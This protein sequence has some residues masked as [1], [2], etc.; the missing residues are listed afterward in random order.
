MTVRGQ[1]IA[2]IGSGVSGLA[3]AW[4]LQY[5]GA[6]VTL[7]EREERCGGHTLTDHSSGTPVDLG[8]QVFN[9]TTYPH[10]VSWLEHLGVDSE[11][12]DMSFAISVDGGTLEWASHNLSTVFAQRK[13]L[14]NWNFLRMVREV[15]RFGREAPKV[16]NEANA[17]RYRDVTLGEYIKAE[18][19][20]EYFRNNYVVPMCAAVWSVPYTQAEQF[21]VQMLVRFWVNH[22]LLDVLQRPLWRV[23]KNRSE[24]YVNAVLPL[25]HR[26]RTSTAVESVTVQQ[27][28]AGQAQACVQFTGGSEV[29]DRVVLATHSDISLRLRGSSVTA[30]EAAILAGIPYADNDVYLHRDKALMPRTPACWASWNVIGSSHAADHAAAVCVSYGLHRL[31]HLPDSCRDLFVTLNPPTPPQE[32]TVISRMSLA[33]PVFSMASWNAQQQLP[34]IQGSGGGVVYYAGAWCGYGFHE[35]GMR[36][37]VAAVGAMGLRVPWEPRATSPKLSMFESWAL[38]RLGQYLSAGIGPGAAL[39]VVRPDGEESTYGGGRSGG[40]SA[41][42]VHVYEV[43]P[44]YA[45]PQAFSMGTTATERAPFGS[46]LQPPAA[47]VGCVRMH[48]A[49]R[50]VKLAATVRV[51]SV[52]A[53]VRVVR[54]GSVGLLRGYREREWEVSD[55]GAFA[56]VLMLNMNA[57]GENA[58]RLGPL[59]WL[60]CVS[61]LSQHVHGGRSIDANYIAAEALVDELGTAVYREVLGPD[62]HLTPALHRPGQACAADGHRRFADAVLT[63]AAVQQGCSVLQ[64]GGGW[65][66]LARQAITQHSCKWTATF[67]S[68]R[69]LEHVGTLAKQQGHADSLACHLGDWRELAAALPA[70]QRFD[71]IVAVDPVTVCGVRHSLLPEFFELLASRLAPGGRATVLAFY[72]APALVA[73]ERRSSSFFKNEVLRGAELPT[74]EEVA[75]A[76]A[77]AEL[78]TVAGGSG[79]ERVDAGG[80]AGDYAATMRQWRLQLAHSW[81]ACVNTGASDW[82]LRQLELSLALMEAALEVGHVQCEL[83]TWTLPADVARAQ[84]VAAAEATRQRALAVTQARMAHHAK[85]SRPVSGEAAAW[86]QALL[87]MLLG[88]LISYLSSWS[89]SG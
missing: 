6:E 84:A 66:A 28:D 44:A 37:A 81:H 72:A 16:L 47:A 14:I 11:A 18:G 76:A 79:E 38:G 4:L 35:D 56:L 64:L 31:Q 59:Q 29:F 63:S 3:A 75:A 7:F 68:R 12:S 69:Q 9:L 24:S 85:L 52:A 61:L 19:Y 43:C 87:L 8:F 86:A 50:E 54:Y 25:L 45:P 1:R 10:F 77:H 21:P 88:Y 2:V 26:V 39:R 71:A 67:L 46:P 34:S 27:G 58:W 5:H 48:D 40:A 55:L 42:A 36:A 22:H 51:L 83:L 20:G 32:D 82:K 57:L 89:R 65:G 23:V 70:T 13:N 60:G 30:G 33:H 41:A 73:A 62:L 78:A 53:A 49:H 74:R 80:L 17:D 15:L